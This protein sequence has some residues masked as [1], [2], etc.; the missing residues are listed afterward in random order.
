MVLRWKSAF[1]AIYLATHMKAQGS[2]NITYGLLSHSVFIPDSQVVA[3]FLLV[4]IPD[5]CLVNSRSSS[6]PVQLTACIRSQRP[7]SVLKSLKTMPS[8]QRCSVIW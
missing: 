3:V 4:C 8:G 1:Q 5:V 7:Y 6:R 2:A